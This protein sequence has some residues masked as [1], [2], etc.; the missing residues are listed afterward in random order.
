MTVIWSFGSFAFF[1]IPFYLGTIKFG[2]VYSMSLAIETAELMASFVCLFITKLISLK[3]SLLLFCLFVCS[4]AVMLL[5]FLNNQGSEPSKAQDLVLPVLLLIINFGTD[6]SF[7]VAYLINTDIFPPSILATAYGVCNVM[8]RLISILAPLVAKA[9][10]PW[11][12]A[13]LIGFS[14][15]CIVLGYFL[16]DRN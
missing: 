9:P 15:I 5:V 4:G 13:I 1:L 2:N 14:S 10:H 11:P 3:N 12:L 7:T 16:K 6:A 8:G